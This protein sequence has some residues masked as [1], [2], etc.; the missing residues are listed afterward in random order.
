[1]GPGFFLLPGA[2]AR[3]PQANARGGA[4]AVGRRGGPLGRHG[5][6]HVGAGGWAR[7]RGG[8]GLVFKKRKNAFL[9]G[10]WS[11]KIHMNG[12]LTEK[13]GENHRFS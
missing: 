9:Q 13:R 2:R 10:V 7:E 4:G 3:W 11:L 8:R 5:V 6:G 1:M 12:L